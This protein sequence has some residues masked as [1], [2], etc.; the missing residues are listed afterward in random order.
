[1]KLEFK[2]QNE[3]LVLVTDQEKT[4][5]T[6]K[7]ET[8]KPWELHIPCLKLL[9]TDE[10]PSRL[11]AIARKKAKEMNTVYRF[12]DNHEDL[13]CC[14][15]KDVDEREARAQCLDVLIAGGWINMKKEMKG[16]DDSTGNS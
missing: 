12:Y 1:M 9:E 10:L 5:G 3:N 13:I 16:N 6:L 8:G 14:I 7:R 2:Q 4:I 15:E 11:V